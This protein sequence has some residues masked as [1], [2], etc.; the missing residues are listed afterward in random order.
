MVVDIPRAVVPNGKEGDARPTGMDGMPGLDP[1]AIGA[2]CFNGANCSANVRARGGESLYLLNVVTG[3]TR[4]VRTRN[5][6]RWD[7]QGSG[8]ASRQ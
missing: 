6:H 3:D 7:G 5:L 1:N 4:G 2:N 8:G